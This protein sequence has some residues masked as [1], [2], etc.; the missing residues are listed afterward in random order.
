MKNN[1]FVTFVANNISFHA[2]KDWLAGSSTWISVTYHLYLTKFKTTK[3]Q[4][5]LL[6]FHY[7]TVSM[8]PG[9]FACHAKLTPSEMQIAKKNLLCLQVL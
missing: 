6:L 2:L 1:I 3:L 4:M 8:K 7:V 9:L 5:C